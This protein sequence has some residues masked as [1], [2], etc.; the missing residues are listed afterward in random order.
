MPKASPLQSVFSG[1]E[2]SSL[3]YGRVDADNYKK[4]LKTCLN[5]LPT[6]QGPVVRRPGTGYVFATKDAGVARLQSFE[7]STTQAYILE[8]GDEYVRFFKNRG[9]ITLA[10]QN[11]SNVNIGGAFPRLTVTG[12]GYATG[13][14][15]VVQGVVGTTQ[16]NNL[17]FE[18]TV[19][20]ANTFDLTS[21]ATSTLDAYVSGGIV[22]KIYEIE[23]DY[24]A[25]DVFDLKFTQSNDVLYIA[26]PNY[27]TK[28]LLRYGDTDWQF[29]DLDLLDG[30]YF[31]PN[32]TQ[33]T[34]TPGAATGDGVT[35]SVGPN[36]TIT[37]A[38]DNGSGLIRI[39]A[40]AHGYSDADSVY[41]ASVVGTTE[42]NGTWTIDLIDAN[43][44]DLRNSTFTNAYVSGGVASPAIFAATDVGRAIR[45]KE[46]ATWGWAVV[47]SYTSPISV[48]IDIKSTLTNTNAKVLWRLGIYSDTTGY[49]GAVTFHEDRL[50]LGGATNAPQRI[51]GS[52]TGDY[53]NFSP[54]NFDGTVNPDNSVGFAF[55]SNDVNVIRWLASDERGLAS[56][57]VAGE[58]ITTPS[59]QGEAL[60]PTNITAKKSTSWGSENVQ[61]VQAGKSIIFVQRAGRKLRELN[62]YFDVGGFRSTDVTQLA[63]HISPVGIKQLAYQKEPQSFVWAVRKDGVLAAM[64]YERD[65]DA[66][67]VGWSRHIL[68]GVSDAANNPAIAE[69][70]QVIPSPDGLRQDTWLIVKRYINGSVVRHIEYITEI[71]DQTSEQR[72]AFFVDA[73]LTYDVPITISGITNANPVVVTANNHGFNDGDKV[74]LTEILGMD[75][76]NG[77][78]ALVDNKTTN[79]F[80]LTDLDGDPINSTSFTPYVSGGMVRKLVLEISSLNHLEGEVVSILADGAVQPEKTVTNGKITLSDKAAV[81]HIG[82]GYNSDGELLRVEAGSAD[83]TALGKT[84]RTHRIGMMLERTLGLKIGYSFDAL[85]V[86]TFRTTADKLTRAPAL[87][88]GIIS[89]TVDSDYDFE[90]TF[91]FRQ[92]QPLPGTIQ[93]VMPQ[94]VTQD[95]G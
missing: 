40:T 20:N 12:H 53:E 85:D 18:I 67:R 16:I 19:I 81:I 23:S 17:E 73:G 68:G 47:A 56:G 28:K 84:R 38:V 37:N 14:R 64:T 66:L 35:L 2:V 11:I 29:K 95:R 80:E 13:D 50:F 71:F 52:K 89:E 94:M 93:A 9:N 45:M 43:T 42:A 61:P 1:G 30:P 51:D 90:N 7:Y 6:L 82:Y 69:S 8:F 41:I 25:A 24:A 22:A 74:L 39:T 49:P 58:W 48:T 3:Y 65:L 55:N 26:H 87:F 59:T 4:S 21:P 46:G 77:I 54:T 33:T 63:E 27:K 91:C 88:S 34:F 57:T 32:S 86:V 72:D 83:G 79:T 76:L 70:V 10:T 36:R 62:Y 5:Y 44:F 15:V 60:T 75:E 78:T 92:D 31:T